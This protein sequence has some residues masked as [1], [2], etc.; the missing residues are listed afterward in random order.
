MSRNCTIGKVAGWT[1]VG[2]LAVG[3]VSRT[4]SRPQQESMLKPLAI[5][6][7]Q[8]TGQHRG[9]PPAGEAEFKQ[10]LGTLGQAQLA[11][12]NVKDVESLFTSARDGKPY[13]VLYG[14]AARANPPAL[15]GAPVI[16]YEQEGVGGRRFVANSLGAV[17]EVDEAR[18]K[19][20]V[21][22]AVEPE[23]GS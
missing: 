5:F 13:V 2:L 10:W 1:L 4:Q 16:A 18:F 21:P 22:G 11:A 19:E 17:E 23:G 8:Y 3:C 15:A 9:Q 14:D 12:F 7:G 6:Y 20:L